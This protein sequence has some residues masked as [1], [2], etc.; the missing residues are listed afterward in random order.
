M[1]NKTTGNTVQFWRDPDLPGVEVRYSRYCEEAFR[2]HVH[3]TYSIGYLESGMTSFELEGKPHTAT[4]GQMVLIGP[5]VVH[6]C[7][8]DLDSGMAYHMFYVDGVWLENVGREV[9]GREV[10]RPVFESPVVDDFPLLQS[11]Q[12][13]H[14]SIVEG[15]GR[16]HKETL[17][18][19]AVGDLLLRHASLGTAS[20]SA[21][22]KEAVARVKE[23]LCQRPEQKVNLD[24]LSEVAHLSRYH[25]LRVFRE[26]VGLPPHAYH[27]Q[28][29]VELGKRLLT[30]G[31]TIIQ[32]ALDSGFTDQSHF[33]RVFKQ[34]TGATPRQYQSD[35]CIEK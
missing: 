10:G 25:L 32:A 1:A 2:M 23:Y 8:P 33:T 28:V 4:A 15:A 7:N 24:T 29:R 6:A 21:P 35:H 9:F 26:E 27:N 30:E 11:W 17:L 12:D 5:N 16:L 18:V 31:A 14:Q 3:S 22:G 13:L 20:D 34:F 19:Q